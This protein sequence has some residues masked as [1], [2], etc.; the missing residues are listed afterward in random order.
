MSLTAGCATGTF[1][2]SA[3]I[4][5]CSRNGFVVPSAG[6][7]QATWDGRDDHGRPAAGGIY[8]ARLKSAAG[9]VSGKLVLQR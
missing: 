9:E 3:V 1:P 8:F 6:A 4:V 5:P 7:Q 2:D